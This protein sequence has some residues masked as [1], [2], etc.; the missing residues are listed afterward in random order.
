MPFPHLALAVAICAAWGFNFLVAKFAVDTVPPLAFAAVRFAVL[1]LV[2]SPLLRPVRGKMKDI[3]IIG[4]TAGAIHFG[5]LFLGMTYST[6]SAA[7]VAVQLNTPFATILAILL[8]GEV[9]RWRRWLGIILCCAGVT[10]I[11]FD[12]AAYVRPVG[13]GIF[14]I[15]ALTMGYASIRMRRL[16]GV[17]ALRLQAWLG[18]IS[19]PILAAVSAFTESGQIEALRQAPPLLWGA[20][21]YTVV[22]AS[23]FGHGGFYWLVQRHEVSKLAALMLLGPVFGVTFGVAV[24]GDPVTMQFYAGAA[25]TL[26]GATV[27]ALRSGK[28][29]ATPDAP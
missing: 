3:V 7:A 21:L 11:T 14:A 24:A 25:V 29:A 22:V 27:I 5:A 17:S 8:L 20:L 10:I 13:V 4:L 15:A 28:R 12:P 19:F 16:Q 2:L 1:A 6:P 18:L 23:I 9:V 26:I